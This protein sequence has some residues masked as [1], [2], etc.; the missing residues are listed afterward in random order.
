M[1]DR[2][3][4]RPRS[5]IEFL[6][7]CRSHAVN[8]GHDKIKSEDIEQ[9]EEQYSTQLVNDLTY[10]I[11]DVFPDAKDIL[12]EFIECPYELDNSQLYEI[13]SRVTSD[14]Y[15]KEQIIDLLLWHGII[16]FRRESGEPSFIYS[17]RYDMKR[18]KTLL[19]KRANSDIIY[20]INP[21]FWKGLEIKM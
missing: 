14:P 9:G 1:V 2:C 3:L 18:L 6:G 15:I 4:M 11:K 10:E 8:L 21:A 12:Y 17:V 19:N 16:G 20:L 7:L 13:I 5:L